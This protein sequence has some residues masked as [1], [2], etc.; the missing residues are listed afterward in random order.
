MQSAMRELSINDIV[1]SVLALLLIGSTVL[2]IFRTS[3]VPPEMWAFNGI[4]IGHY[5]RQAADAQSIRVY[6]RLNG[7]LERKRVELVKAA[8][9]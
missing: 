2:M 9:K 4:I 8:S 6:E 7:N 3:A 1:M 5:F